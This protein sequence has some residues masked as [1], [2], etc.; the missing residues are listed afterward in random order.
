MRE[1]LATLEGKRCRWRATYRERRQH[2]RGGYGV[3]RCLFVAVC[4]AA[5]GA[6]FTDHVHFDLCD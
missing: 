1:S 2:T 6:E 3:E 4:D 5:T